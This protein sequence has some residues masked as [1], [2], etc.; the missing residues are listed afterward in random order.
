METARIDSLVSEH[1]N[2]SSARSVL[3]TKINEACTKAEGAVTNMNAT[4]D[5]VQSEQNKYSSMKASGSNLVNAVASVKAL[6][7]F[8][9]LD[10]LSGSN[11][12]LQ[13]I[14]R[15]FKKASTP[16]LAQV[17]TRKGD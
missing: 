6:F 13:R 8:D 11:T 17:I 7:P 9:D 2:N 15:E 14:V 3:A 10:S 4:I 12:Y 16:L 1:K 5:S